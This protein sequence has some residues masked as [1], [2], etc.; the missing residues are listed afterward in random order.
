MLALFAI[1]EFVGMICAGGQW[2][3]PIGFLGNGAGVVLM[4][5][6]MVIAYKERLCV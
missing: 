6:G 2:D 4:L 1:L 5:I 3:Q